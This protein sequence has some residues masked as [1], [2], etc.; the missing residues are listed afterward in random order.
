MAYRAR[1]DDAGPGAA[2]AA[3]REAIMRTKDPAGFPSAK[4]GFE[5]WSRLWGYTIADMP[6][7]ADDM[8]LLIDTI[9]MRNGFTARAD[10]WRT[11]GIGPDRG[12][13]LLARNVS[14]IDWPIWKT[15][16]DAA[17]GE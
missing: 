15:A 3:L 1:K 9:C 6:P 17:L 13:G 8:S 4:E 10:A 7:T 2:Q 16:R 5:V 12:R 11:I 14:A